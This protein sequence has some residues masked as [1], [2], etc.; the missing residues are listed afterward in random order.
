VDDE[1][2]ATLGLFCASLEQDIQFQKL[3]TSGIN[4]VT[5]FRDE[6][7]FFSEY[8]RLVIYAVLGQTKAEEIWGNRTYPEHGGLHALHELYWIS[9][10]LNPELSWSLRQ[11]QHPT[12]KP[13]ESFSSKVEPSTIKDRLPSIEK[14]LRDNVVGQDEA[15]ET[16]LDVLYRAAAGLADPDRP[17]SVLLFTGPSGSGK[18]HL[19]KCL[20]VALFTD[21]PSPDKIGTPEAFMRIDC[22]LYQQRHEISNLIGSPQGYV[23]SD[24]GSPLPD[25]LEK[26]LT[27]NIILIDEVEKAHP[28]LHTMF[29]GLFDY[30]KIKDNKQKEVEAKNTIF[31]MTSNA[32]SREA[33]EGLSKAEKPLGFVANTTDLS[34]LTK[35]AYTSRL[36]ELFTPEFRGRVDEVVIF[37]HLDDKALSRVLDLEIGKLCK[38]LNKRGVTLKVTP[39]ARTAIVKEA[40]S[41]E[42][43]ARRLS[44]FVRES[45]TKPLSKLVVLSDDKKFVCRNV[46]GKF[47]VEPAKKPATQEGQ[48]DI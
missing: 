17:Q 38:R 26:N 41:P 1:S 14:F 6:T 20:A 40:C 19:A 9:T 3:S 23:G 36:K 25:F 15:I 27:G 2:I 33:S 7:S 16:I 45:L 22:T 44:Q 18:T 5:R 13:K 29:M 10:Q 42:L 35:E 31:I 12:P 30:G 46:D 47:I 34:G 39:S 43:G 11:S 8:A 4:K 32:G 24:L 37:N 48:A 28:A 21:A